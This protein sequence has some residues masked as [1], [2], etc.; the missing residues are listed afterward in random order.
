[1]NG[2]WETTAE[3]S[4]CFPV[5]MLDEEMKK[6]KRVKYTVLAALAVTMTLFCGCAD[7]PKAVLVET[8][9]AVQETEQ[10]STDRTGSLQG[11]L[12]TAAED[13]Q[14]RTEQSKEAEV[15]MEF[16]AGSSFL[17]TG[18]ENGWSRI[19]YQGKTLYVP[20][21][22]LANESADA[23]DELDEELQKAAEEGSAFISSLEGQREADRNNRIWRIIIIV[24]IAA[25]FVSG[26]VSSLGKNRRTKDSDV[27]NKEDK[28]D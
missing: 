15:V 20:Q 11:S 5:F 16:P 22:S 1:M 14:G 23:G 12:M 13:T 28:K 6:R 10:E 27:D 19:F 24:L 18:E 4:G 17:V 8:G 9:T 25:V 26:I 3:G 21:E 2:D 7:T